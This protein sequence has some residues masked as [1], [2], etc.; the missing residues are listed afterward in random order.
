LAFS[1]SLSA[2]MGKFLVVPG[3]VAGGISEGAM[4]LEDL[5]SVVAMA[6]IGM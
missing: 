1:I 3:N 6:L 4:L 2:D 5:S